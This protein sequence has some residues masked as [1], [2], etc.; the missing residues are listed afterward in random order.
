MTTSNSAAPI[1]AYWVREGR[2]LAGQYPGSPDPNVA[3]R[4]IRYLLSRGIRR[5]IDLTEAD[6]K[7]WWTPGN[8]PLLP[9]VAILEEEAEKSG[10]KVDHRRFPITD[11]GVPT[12]EGMSNILDVIDASLAEGVPTYVHCV[13]GK[14]RT[15]IVVAC[16]MIRH[17]G[18]FLPKAPPH[19]F[20][21]AALGRL[22]RIRSEQ[23][24]PDPQDS[25]QNDLQRKFVRSWGAG[26]VS[27]AIK[28]WELASRSKS[29]DKI[30]FLHGRRSSPET[31]AMAQS[32][33]E[34]F[35]GWD[36]IV[37]DYRPMERSHAEIES[38]LDELFSDLVPKM[39]NDTLCCIGSSLGG[40]WAYWVARRWGKEI[41][42]RFGDKAFLDVYLLNPWLG[43]YPEVPLEKPESWFPLT[44]FLNEDD[45]VID[46]KMAME[47]LQ[48]NAQIVTYPNGGHRF[49]N[50]D[51]R[52]DMLCRIGRE[53]SFMSGIAWD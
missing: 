52:R 5:F 1:D 18:G 32:I 45:D 53:I 12:D 40:Y 19:T 9:Y 30:V 7:A 8:P 3:R 26:C 10:V 42:T 27:D 43:A 22:V 46:P 38:Y 23:G 44:V 41:A 16:H 29:G 13:G 31:S 33:R 47:W 37:P 14:G 6:E 51:N 35:N 4:K 28:R 50:S 17:A 20:V 49:E 15:G 11:M 21:E 48:G 39:G 25:P 2:L 34:H 36:V 24:V